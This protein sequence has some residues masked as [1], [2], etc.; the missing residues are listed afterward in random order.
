MTITKETI[1]KIY[2]IFNHMHLVTTYATQKYKPD[3]EYRMLILIAK[4]HTYSLTASEVYCH[5]SKLT[6]WHLRIWK[7]RQKEIPHTAFCDWIDTEKIW[8]LGFRDT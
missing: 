4:D 3:E 5:A 2:I 8:R 6:P 1:D 7:K